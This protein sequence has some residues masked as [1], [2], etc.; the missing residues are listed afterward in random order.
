MIRALLK[1]RLFGCNMFAGICCFMAVSGFISGCSD[2]DT[3]RNSFYVDIILPEE[4]AVFRENEAVEFKGS[5]VN[6]EGDAI[7]YGSLIWT[8]DIDG[9]LGSGEEFAVDAL[10]FGPHRICLS[11]S[12]ADNEGSETCISIDVRS[13]LST[14]VSVGSDHVLTVG[15]DGGLW[16]WGANERGQIG[17]GSTASSQTFIPIGVESKWIKAAAGDQFSVGI[18]S[19]GTLWFWGRDPMDNYSYQDQVSPVLL[20]GDEEWEDVD[21]SDYRITAIRSDGRCYFWEGGHSYIWNYSG[22]IGDDPN[23]RWKAV[24][25]GFRHVLLIKT[26]GTMWCR[27][28]SYSIDGYDRFYNLNNWDWFRQI[29]DRT[30]WAQIDAYE[31]RGVALS[32]D[33]SLYLV[34]FEDDGVEIEQIGNQTGWKRASIGWNQ[35]AAVSSD[36]SLWTCSGFEQEQ[37]VISLQQYDSYN[38]FLTVS[39]G[40]NF[41]VALTNFGDPVFIG[42]PP[43]F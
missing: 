43:L 21:A 34:T 37:A 18:K 7:D 4:G 3:P 29:G 1:S 20:N 24:A 28:Q 16:A 32:E 33:G 35:C 5:G 6:S 42:E 15:S 17:D 23:D 9:F 27:S 22:I 25:T 13:S 36:D 31:N 40:Y 12:D 8:S 2:D 30:D 26:D 11:A 14:Q 39:S 10:S 41:S 19:D 38:D